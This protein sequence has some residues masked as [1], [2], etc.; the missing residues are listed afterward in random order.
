LA[1]RRPTGNPAWTMPVY[2]P[3]VFPGCV[4]VGHQDG[5]APFGAVGQALDDADDDEQDSGP[6]ADGLVGGQAADE[7]GGDAHHEQAGDQDGFAAEFVAEV[8]ADDPAQ[9]ADEES[10]DE[11]GEGQ[12]GG[13]QRVGA[14][15]EVRPEVQGGGGAVADEVVG[16]DGDPAP[17]VWT[18]SADEILAK[19]RIVQTNIRKLVENNTKYNAVQLRNPRVFCRFKAG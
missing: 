1:S 15:E 12:Q 9:R 8:A 17:F 10:D 16:L 3:L 13:G 18:A 5:A 14:G 7:E 2:L 6:D 4:F 19:V 11:G